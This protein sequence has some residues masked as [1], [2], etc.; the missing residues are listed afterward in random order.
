[1]AN[2]SASRLHGDDYQHLYS[3]LMMHDLLNPNTKID[4]I[5]IEHPSAGAADDLTIHPKD[6]TKYAT[7]FY[8]VKGH[9][10]LSKTYSMQA[11]ITP[12]SSSSR[13]L[14]RSLW[15]SWRELRGQGYPDIEVWLVSDWLPDGFLGNLIRDN[16]LTE[17]FFAKIK[18]PHTDVGKRCGA[19]I[20]HL[21]AN[22]EDFEA[23]CRALHFELG[24]RSAQLERVVDAEMR[25]YGLKSG[26]EHRGNAVALVR[27]WIKGGRKRRITA[28]QLKTA[29]FTRNLWVSSQSLTI[30]GV[31]IDSWMTYLNDLG[32]H[33]SQWHIPPELQ[34][35]ITWD[36][37]PVPI[38][39]YIRLKPAFKPSFLP[40]V[41]K[42]A[43]EKDSPPILCLSEVMT[44][45]PVLIMGG[46]GA[47]KS[48]CLKSLCHR[49]S[50][51]A[52][53]RL[54]HGKDPYEV[55]MPVLI[56]LREY[57][58]VRLEEL[59]TAQ[60]RLYRLPITK[61]HLHSMLEKGRL[62]LLLD[63]LDEVRSQWRDDLVNEL[64][65][66][67]ESYPHHTIV[68]TTRKQ[69]TPPVL[70]GF[71]VYE[72][73][74]LENQAIQAFVQ[75]YLGYDRY[76]FLD[77][78][79]ERGIEDLSRV[80][81]L[82]TLC[83]IVFRREK[84]AFDSL[85]GVY[86]KVVELYKANWE[87]PGGPRRV[88]EP[89]DWVVLEDT[90]SR[91]AY[92]MVRDG[93][94]FSLSRQ[95]LLAI[96][97]D[98]VSDLDSAHLWSRKHTVYDL[99]RQLLAHNFLDSFADEVSFWH[100]SFR[101]FFAARFV[102]RLHLEQVIAH[103][104]KRDW[105]LVTAFLGGLLPDAQPVCE[106]LMNAS[107][108][109]ESLAD[110]YWPIE[111]LGLMGSDTTREIIRAISEPSY[112]EVHNLAGSILQSRRFKGAEIF[113]HVFG[114]LGMLDAISQGDMTLEDVQGWLPDPELIDFK[115]FNSLYTQVML[116]LSDGNV[117]VAEQYEKKLFDYLDS[118]VQAG[119]E[120]DGWLLSR[121]INTTN[122]FY[123]ALRFR[124][125]SKKDLHSFC[126]NT[127][128][129]SST[130]F[131]E[132]LLWF[133]EDADLRREASLAIQCLIRQ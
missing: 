93:N 3:W 97:K 66:L 96:L 126:R 61:A 39:D 43:Q 7:R 32:A 99:M 108:E 115:A 90:L 45:A 15:D 27:E 67:H 11:L 2:Q 86:K 41:R 74:P 114:M 28:D 4:H 68:V 109:S 19:W 75:T 92:R 6:P 103:A 84:P 118:L 69:P 128:L 23:F 72:I 81:L 8:Q 35:L 29:I 91:L 87:G 125:L 30:D 9:R 38:D 82:L 127:L 31:A 78:M 33:H 14:L 71:E 36:V 101:D 77:Q 20:L 83:L 46:A 1:M 60:L 12:T 129:S 104:T 100:A 24:Y 94:A 76:G 34:P 52:R 133:T 16:W 10:D 122:D 58:P 123:C 56:T 63:G 53:N 85:A 105:A 37:A 116:A 50:L 98:I 124:H 47:G 110:A 42:Q 48:T 5:W 106:A 49:L 70:K 13:S 111:T 130:R 65:I 117:A 95:N 26:D 62:V 113:N 22:D 112:I 64:V 54:K 121:G 119:E 131:L 73:Q 51:E 18:R 132:V 80:P 89:I 21:E 44:K 17:E 25:S 120:L 88:D 40:E 102:A 57:G 55:E 79:G 107:L 59:I